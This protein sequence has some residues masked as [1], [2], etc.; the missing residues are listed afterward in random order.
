VVRWSVVS[1]LQENY[2]LPLRG[3]KEAGKPLLTVCRQRSSHEPVS[4]PSIAV[5]GLLYTLRLRRS[6]LAWGPTSQVRSASLALYPKY[7]SG[8]AN[9]QLLEQGYIVTASQTMV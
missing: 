2:S 6:G 3:R 8:E 1:K 5:A 7:R 4:L 9:Y